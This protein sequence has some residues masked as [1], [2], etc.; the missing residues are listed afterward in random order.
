MQLVLMRIITNQISSGGKKSI[1]GIF[2][3][4]STKVKYTIIF[5]TVA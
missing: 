5:V 1:Q 4:I 2:C 3:D